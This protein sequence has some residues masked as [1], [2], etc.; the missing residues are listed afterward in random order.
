MRK[1]IDL[2]LAKLPE[3][4]PSEWP[5]PQ[6]LPDGLPP[7]QPFDP[8]LLPTTLRPWVMDIADR[9]QCAPDYVAATVMAALG[10]TIGRKL[11]IRPQ[12]HTDWT[13]TPNQWAMIIGRP[14]VL[15]SPAMEAALAP[16]KHLS[17]KAIQAFDTDQI[18]YKSKKKLHDLMMSEA[19]KRAKKFIEKGDKPMTVLAKM[20]E[21]EGEPET[22]KLRRY[23]AVNTTAEA[24]GELH[25][26]NPNGLLIHRDEMVSLLKS[27]DREDNS[28]ARG[29][30]LTGWNGDS[31]YT[32]DRIGRG[33]NLHIDAVCLSMLGSTQPG[34]IAEYISQAVLGGAG[35]DGL[36]QRFGLLVWPD[37]T[38]WRD[39]D[40][41]PDSEA[42]RGG[43]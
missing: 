30:Y 18:E 40:R 39:V 15:K 32:F 20:L 37:Q 22:P 35:D 36:I 10:S 7:V 34:R 8:K 42:K 38:S 21:V 17:G 26:E 31:S 12:E 23:I 2:S 4:D 9:V 25:R 33:L 28:E 1:M 11:G 19:E 6:P 43:I 41:L 16:L 14:G 24:L 27:L 5:E 3:T 29:F 13:V